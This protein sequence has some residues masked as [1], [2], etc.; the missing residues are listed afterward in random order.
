MRSRPGSA[1]QSSPDGT[2]TRLRFSAASCS[3]RS[4]RSGSV[5][6]VR[7]RALTS[8]CEA[9][10]GASSA[11]CPVRMLTT[12]PG[13]SDV[14]ST[15]ARVIAGSGVRSAATTTQVLPVTITGATTETSPSSGSAGA[16]TATTPVGSGVDRLKYGPAT[17]L[18]VL[19]TDAIL[20]DQPAYQTS[21]STA[22]S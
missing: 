6:P 22:A 13:R 5:T 7:S 12:P 17:G 16:T 2:N 8:M 15:S 14:A 19:W 10:Q 9:S 21:R 18:A 3:Q 20:S 4:A 11:W 1:D